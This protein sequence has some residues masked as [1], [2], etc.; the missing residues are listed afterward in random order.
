MPTETANL[1]LA[2]VQP[3]QANKSATVNAAFD[4]LD[5]LLTEKTTLTFA[6]AAGVYAVSLAQSRRSWLI[7]AAGTL[8]AALALEWPA[9]KRLFWF[10]NAIT[11]GYDLTVRCA[12]HPGIVVRNGT[13]EIL[14]C[15]G[16]DV[17]FAEPLKPYDFQMFY[18][19]VPQAGEVVF[20]HRLA[21][22]VVLPAGLPGS[23]GSAGT[24]PTGT[25]ALDLRKNGVSIG[26]VTFAAGQADPAFT[27]ALDQILLPA[28]ILTLHMPGAVDP[29]F[30]S[31]CLTLAGRRE[32]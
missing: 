16:S 6:G 28:D 29:T 5:A 7:A 19:G 20:R 17:G 24:A 27:L 21:R 18:G 13:T 15:D 4:A 3:A 1:G 32:H 30:A 14:Y 11:N 31:F 10:H 2:Y 26:T 23:Q 25:V 12:G 8:S 9:R 22:V